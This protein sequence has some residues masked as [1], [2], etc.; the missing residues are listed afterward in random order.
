MRD[1]MIAFWKYVRSNQKVKENM[2]D[3]STCKKGI[4]AKTG[5]SKANILNSFFCIFTEE[6]LNTINNP[7][8]CYA[9]SELSEL[10]ITL[11]IV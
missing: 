4:Y 10:S 5:V 6:K 7:E 1:N 3:L 8:I 2:P 11:E 9:Q